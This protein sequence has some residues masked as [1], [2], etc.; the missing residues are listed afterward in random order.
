[1]DI[2]NVGSVGSPFDGDTRASYGR[3]EYRNSGWHT[4]I[5]R[6]A[7]DRSATE[8]EFRD[9]GFLDQG[10]GLARI[11]FHEWKRAEML[12]RFWSKQY[13]EAVLAGEIGLEESVDTFLAGIG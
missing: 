6:L 7:Y 1:M 9:S 11:I 8:R 3:L 10:G 2:I 13:Q 12:I 4:E 5:V